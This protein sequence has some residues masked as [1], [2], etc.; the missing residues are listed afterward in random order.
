LIFDN[1][2]MPNRKILWVEDTAL[3]SYVESIQQRVGSAVKELSFETAA[4]VGQARVILNQTKERIDLLITDIGVRGNLQAFILELKSKFPEAK[5]LLYS[6]EW[7]PEAHLER[8]GGDYAI[9]KSG[10]E[11]FQKVA[12]YILEVFPELYREG[13]ETDFR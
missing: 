10:R 11:G 7:H 3:D 4:T 5:V 13:R 9:S 6:A 1:N 8:L 2:L 12:N